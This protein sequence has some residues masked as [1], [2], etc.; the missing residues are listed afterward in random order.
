M[1]QDFLGLLKAEQWDEVS[2]A[3][4]RH[5][6]IVADTWDRQW[7]DD[8]DENLPWLW[9]FGRAG[10]TENCEPAEP[11]PGPILLYRGCEQK[12]RLHMS[13]T[14]VY[15]LAVMYAE[16]ICG[17]GARRLGNIYAHQAWPCEL[18]AHIHRREWKQTESVYD[19]FV[20]DCSYLNDDNVEPLEVAPG[21]YADMW[22]RYAMSGRPTDFAISR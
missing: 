1:P 18:L 10:Y 2:A 3:I 14:P 17:N 9:A 19:E 16:S 11:P 5:P 4:E 22:V 20:L 21:N 12:R 7:D 15:G 13:W 6:G 8:W